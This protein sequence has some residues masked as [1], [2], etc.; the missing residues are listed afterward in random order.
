MQNPISE[1]IVLGD[2]KDEP[3]RTGVRGEGER[4]GD[5]RQDEWGI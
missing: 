5:V 1:K 2:G 3:G 4:G